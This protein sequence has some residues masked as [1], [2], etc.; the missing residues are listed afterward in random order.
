MAEGYFKYVR[1]PYAPTEETLINTSFFLKP[2]VPLMTTNEHFYL[3]SISKKRPKFFRGDIFGLQYLPIDELP[4]GVDDVVHFEE[5]EDENLFRTGSSGAGGGANYHGVG[6]GKP[7]EKKHVALYLEEVDDTLWKE[8]LHKENVPLVL[9]G[10]EYLI[11]IYKSVTDYKNIWSES[12]TGNH[13]HDD[14][15]HLYEQVRPLIEPY[16]KERQKKALLS[17]GN[18]SATALTSSILADIIPAA[19][20]G[21]VSTLFVRMDEHIWGTFDEM[22]N[23]LSVHDTQQEGDECLID[24]AVIKTILNDGDV[25]FLSREEM[26]VDSPIAVLLRY[27]S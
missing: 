9:A 3:L 22:N 12:L 15:H 20:Y 26:P 7:D 6:A 19:Y 5:K 10:V 13:E 27:A 4:T 21:Q 17:Y 16:F 25:Y 14:L 2:L 23:K 1:L 8:V 18:Q 11:P 24:K